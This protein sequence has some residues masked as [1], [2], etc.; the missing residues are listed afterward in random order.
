[1][2]M[3]SIRSPPKTLSSSPVSKIEGVGK[4]AQKAMKGE[5]Q[6]GS[7]SRGVGQPKRVIDEGD[8]G[9]VQSSQ[10]L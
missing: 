9:K 7:R 8:E 3:G 6:I 10:P 2:E 4:T 5:M 1:M